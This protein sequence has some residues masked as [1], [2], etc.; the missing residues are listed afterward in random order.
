M[1]T[2]VTQYAF[3][4]NSTFAYTHSVAFLFDFYLVSYSLK[5]SFGF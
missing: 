4:L 1:G 3:I 2:I 5:Y